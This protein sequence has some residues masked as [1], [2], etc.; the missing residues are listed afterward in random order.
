LGVGPWIGAVLTDGMFPLLLAGGAFAAIVPFGQLGGF[1]SHLQWLQIL[2]YALMAAIVA[3]ALAFAV[4]VVWTDHQDRGPAD[5][6]T[7]RTTG[8]PREGVAGHFASDLHVETT[9]R[10]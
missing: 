3:A 6:A 2:E 5:S 9:R 8:K 7:D 1:E 10:H 4:Y